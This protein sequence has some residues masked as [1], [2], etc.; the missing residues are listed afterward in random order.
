MVIYI[1]KKLNGRL[2]ETK[3]LTV[4]GVLKC[5]TIECEINQN[6]TALASC[7]YRC[8]G[9]DIVSFNHTTI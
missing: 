7:V 6:K 5:V 4:D 8:P 1:N 3:S 2:C 9:S